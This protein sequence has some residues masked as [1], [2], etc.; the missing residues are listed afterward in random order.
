VWNGVACLYETKAG[1]VL[2]NDQGAS[3][4]AFVAGGNVKSAGAMSI[5]FR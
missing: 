5:Y 2:Y 3:G 1:K 4:T